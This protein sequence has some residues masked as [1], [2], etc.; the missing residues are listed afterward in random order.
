MEIDFVLQEFGT[1]DKN[2]S[3]NNDWDELE[4]MI[5]GTADYATLPIPNRSVMKC[6]YPEFEEEYMKSVAGFYPQQIIDEQNEDLEI[7]S[8]TLKE[9]GVKVYRPDTQYALEDT[10]SPTWEGKNWH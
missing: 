3:C 10:K 2:M 5:V 1:G 7:L 9:L 6:Q 4:E 8:D